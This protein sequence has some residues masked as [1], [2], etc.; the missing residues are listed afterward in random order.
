M[1]EERIFNDEYVN[2][3]VNK[4]GEASTTTGVNAYELDNEPALWPSTH[5]RIHPLQT[6]CQEIIQKSVALSKAVK[7][8]DST[9]EIF[10]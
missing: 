5:P 1:L 7:S 2:F 8:I 10:G 4:Y 9:A 3:L 6:T